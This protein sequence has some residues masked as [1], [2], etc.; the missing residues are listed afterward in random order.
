M[1]KQMNEVI[2][3]KILLIVYGLML[4]SCSVWNDE[5][6]E[7]IPRAMPRASI[8]KISTLVDKGIIKEEDEKQNGISFMNISGAHSSRFRDEVVW[9]GAEEVQSI[10]LLPYEDS[11][12]TFHAAHH[13]YA[14]IRPSSWIIKSQEKK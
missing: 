1:I 8:H 7:P 10:Y 9:R 2:L 14:V 12:N 11:E 6:D 4:A 5:F 3:S 13:L